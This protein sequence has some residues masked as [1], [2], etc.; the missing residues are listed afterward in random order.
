[1]RE[2]KRQAFEFLK[3]LQACLSERLP[4]PA[5]ISDEINQRWNKPALEKE[6]QEQLAC[7]ENIFLYHFALPE[8]ANHMQSHCGLNPTQ[9]REALRGEYFQKFPNLLSSNSV[10]R[11]GH[12]FGK[13]L[14]KSPKDIMSIWKSGGKAG[15]LNQAYPDLCFSAP[16]PFTIVCDAKFFE[17][18]SVSAAEKALVEGV[19]E[20]AF[21]R[22]LVGIPARDESEPAWGYDFG[23]LLAYDASPGAYLHQAWHS[24]GSRHLFW[25]DANVFVMIVRG[26]G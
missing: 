11:Q 20:A 16:L 24:I 7:K 12:P 8:I 15:P 21:Y 3:S 18:P 2:K 5:V 14:G 4:Q 22:G 6:T 26:Q 19:Y 1:M 17:K 10:R 9:V 25:E 13:A 23:C